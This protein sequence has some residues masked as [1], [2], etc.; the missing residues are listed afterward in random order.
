[1]YFMPDIAAKLLGT[2]AEVGGKAPVLAAQV[3]SPLASSTTFARPSA[4]FA[5]IRYLR[6]P[7]IASALVMPSRGTRAA[8]MIRAMAQPGSPFFSFVISIRYP[9]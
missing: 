4:D 6:T 2:A 8:T 5:L 3:A 7:N 1:M 9:R